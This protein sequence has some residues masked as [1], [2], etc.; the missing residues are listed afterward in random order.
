M[1]IETLNMRQSL[2]GNPQLT[3]D[4]LAIDGLWSLIEGHATSDP[5]S[6]PETL[7]QT[8][9]DLDYFVVRDPDTA[10]IVGAVSIMDSTEAHAMIADIA[11]APSHRGQGYGRA[12][13]VAAVDHCTKHG[14]KEIMTYALPPSQ[15]LFTSLGFET[16]EISETGNA[17]MF[18]ER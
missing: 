15:R 18:L 11:V 13:A 16:Y 2:A 14:C 12:L 10:T 3:A 8:M 17:T 9:T 1:A 6:D 7:R 4:V 5:A